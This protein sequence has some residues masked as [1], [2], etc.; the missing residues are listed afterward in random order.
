MHGVPLQGQGPRSGGQGQLVVGLYRPES[1]DPG[2]EGLAASGEA[3]EIVRLHASGDDD[4]VGPEQ[5]LVQDYRR[6]VPRGA[7]VHQVDFLAGLVRDATRAQGPEMRAEQLPVFRLGRPPVGPG[8]H[9]DRDP[10]RPDPA[11]REGGHKYVQHGRGRGRAGRVVD[12]HEH[13]ARSGQEGVQT[14]C[15]LAGCRRAGC[16]RRGR[17]PR[18]RALGQ[19]PAQELRGAAPGLDFV[20]LDNS[21][22]GRV[23]D[24][25]RQ[26]LSKVG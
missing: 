17:A 7:Q 18:C 19:C 12:D 5:V 26:E 23:G 10:R 16:G 14:G 2:K 9:E 25:Q 24:L 21:H 11:F 13:R 15:G 8:R 6:P 20:G 4:A 22:Q 1:R 3:G